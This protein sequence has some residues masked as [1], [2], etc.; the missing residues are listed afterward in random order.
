VGA[1]RRTAVLVGVVTAVAALDGGMMESLSAAL[2][3]ELDSELE[4]AAQFVQ[5]W[6]PVFRSL[7]E[8]TMSF[9]YD[10]DV[11]A[12]P[13]AAPTPITPEPSTA[14]PTPETP[15]PTVTPTT[16]MPTATRTAD[17]TMM[18]TLLPV[19]MPSMVPTVEP[20]A[21]PSS[22]PTVDCDGSLL[23]QLFFGPDSDTRSSDWA[24][25]TATIFQG[26]LDSTETP[27]EELQSFTPSDA[28]YESFCATSE[29]CYLLDV[30][31][32]GV[33]SSDLYVRIKTAASSLTTFVDPSEDGIDMFFCVDADGVFNRA[34]SPA[35]T[36]VP[37]PMPTYIPTYVPSPA[38]TTSP[39]PTYEPSMVPTSIPTPAP[40]RAIMTFTI[41]FSMVFP[42]SLSDLETLLEEWCVDEGLAYAINNIA[43]KYYKNTV[44][45]DTEE[46]DSIE[47][48]C[49]LESVVGGTASYDCLVMMFREA[50]QQSAEGDI[51]AQEAQINML[52]E[53]EEESGDDLLDD[54]IEGI[55]ES[56]D[57]SCLENLLDRRRLQS[58]GGIGAILNATIENITVVVDT[59]SP[60]GSPTA[61][62]T[63]A[64]SFMPTLVPTDAGTFPPTTE[65][66]AP[67]VT[68][69]PTGPECVDDA[70]CPPGFVCDLGSRRRGRAL[71]FG[72]TT[73]TCVPE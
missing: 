70:D 19:P 46:L 30:S 12:S 72:Y 3:E 54:V 6:Q 56:D 27:S 1:M 62:P 42:S 45:L 21:A 58:S 41:G 53:V 9:S 8:T 26:E 35:P 17:P 50:G 31:L 22:F 69:A 48:S 13:T 60:S 29:Q 47:T 28:F 43:T 20:S 32:D 63:I 14:A 11:T 73:G 44:D 24:S 49:V 23:F 67:T 65:T 51:T 71:L 40:T 18:P 7:E 36:Y 55:E 10:F 4:K 15:Y 68:A 66:P 5:D 34:P 37:S 64:P 33:S 16:Y 59:A 2:I 25:A 38:P 52:V 57:A 39:E 61:P